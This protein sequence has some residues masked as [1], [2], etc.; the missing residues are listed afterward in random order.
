M[1]FQID[2]TYLVSGI[3]LVLSGMVMSG[4]LRKDQ[5]TILGPFRDGSWMPISI[6]SLHIKRVPN[7]ECQSPLSCS[8][9]VRAENLHR[10]QIRKGMVLLDADEFKREKPLVSRIFEA[11]VVVLQ[12]P[13]TIKTNYQAVIHCGQVRQSAQILS[14][15]NRRKL[16]DSKQKQEEQE[17]QKEQKNQEETKE[18]K[19]QKQ[20]QE[21]E[22]H[23]RIGDKAIVVFRFTRYDEYIHQGMSFVF[24][25]GGCKGIGKI[26]R[27]QHHFKE[28]ELKT[29]DQSRKNIIEYRRKSHK[30]R[31]SKGKFL[32]S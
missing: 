8:V 21:E 6:R 32:S 24:R 31:Y 18:Q 23:L 5:N 22:V 9:S 29:I 15:R 10:S 12:H 27:C 28:E 1:E 14:I 19:E 17:E 3:G 4:T 30:S 2:E 16:T 7:E 20:E 11:E 26:I 25:E 13:T